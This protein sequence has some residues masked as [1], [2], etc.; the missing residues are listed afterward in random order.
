[1]ARPRRADAQRPR[2][3]R[4]PRL[5]PRPGLSRVPR[6]AARGG[7]RAPHPWRHRP[8]GPPRRGG[9]RGRGGV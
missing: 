4:Q 3:R 6:R 7:D 9:A 5:P 8:P 1:G 2:R